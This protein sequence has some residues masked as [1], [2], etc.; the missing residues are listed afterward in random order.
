[1]QKKTR[2]RGNSFHIVTT[3]NS[4]KSDRSVAVALMLKMTAHG[5]SKDK[6]DRKSSVVLR[7]SKIVKRSQIELNVT[8]KS[9]SKLTKKQSK[10]IKNGHLRSQENDHLR[11]QLL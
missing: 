4:T 7:P 10:L 3:R 6:S 2:T 11:S 1:M 9:H 5:H 8:N